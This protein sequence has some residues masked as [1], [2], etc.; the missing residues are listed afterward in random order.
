MKVTQ[1]FL[2]LC[3]PKDYTVPGI[4]HARILEWVAFAQLDL[5]N[6]GIKPRPPTL[7]VDSL[8]AEPPVENSRFCSFNKLPCDVRC[9]WSW[10]I[11][12]VART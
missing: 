1:L 5:P 6:P 4:L 11:L 10:V 12:W 7:Q 9:C 8:P 3:N 2:T